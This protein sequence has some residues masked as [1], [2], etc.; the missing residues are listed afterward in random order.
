MNPGQGISAAEFIANAAEEEIAR[1]FKEYGEE[2]FAKRMARAI[3]RAARRHPF[4]RTAESVESSQQ[5]QTRLGEGQE[6]GDP[7][8]PGPAHP[9]EQ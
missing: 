6:S 4:R 7:R 2:R 9:C 5:L 8:I 3:V 1:V